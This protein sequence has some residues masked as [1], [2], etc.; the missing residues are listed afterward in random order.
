MKRDD[1]YNRAKGCEKKIVLLLIFVILVILSMNCSCPTEKEKQSTAIQT[2]VI[3]TKDKYDA[4]IVQRV[5]ISSYL[6]QTYFVLTEVWTGKNG[7]VN[8]LEQW[9]GATVK[10]E[11]IEK[12]KISQ[13]NKA[14]RVK[15]KLDSIFKSMN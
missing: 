15:C 11:E 13:M 12:T 4:N 8:S 9:E 2:P 7:H 14:F 5:S 10:K 6:D 1:Y 3:K